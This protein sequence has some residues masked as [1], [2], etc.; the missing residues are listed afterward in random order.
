MDEERFNRYVNLGISAE[1][2]LIRL[3]G[4]LDERDL[5]P[6]RYPSLKDLR[7]LGYRAVCLGS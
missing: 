3:D 2:M 6:F 1:D 5:E 7:A 4:F